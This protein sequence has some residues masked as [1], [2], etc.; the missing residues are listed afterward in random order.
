MCWF[1]GEGDVFGGESRP[2]WGEGGCLCSTTDGRV[3][4]SGKLSDIGYLYHES[5]LLDC[6]ETAEGVAKAETLQWTRCL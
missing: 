3:R 1:V 5:Q 2:W 4:S 6:M